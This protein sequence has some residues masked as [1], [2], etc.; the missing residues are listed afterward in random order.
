M[1]AS[2]SNFPVSRQDTIGKLSDDVLLNIFRYY[3]DA[4]PRSWPRLTRICRK[5]RHI[6]FASQRAL[7]VRLLCTHGTPVP[8]TLVC[9]PTLPVVVQYGAPPVPGLPVTEDEDNLNIIAALKQVDRVSSISLIVTNSLLKKLSAIER[10]FSELEDLVLLSQDSVSLMPSAFRWG[11][12]LHTLH[13]TRT[14]IPA[15]LELLL[16]STGLVDLKLHK[17]PNLECLPPDALSR[18]P[19][20][21]SLS[22][23]L[24]SFPLPRNDVGLPT[25][26]GERV[27]LPALTCFKYRGT[28]KYLDSFVARIDAPHLGEID[29]TFFCQPT[30]DAFQLR[31]F[32]QRIEMQ[33]SLS[34]A[35]VETSTHAISISFT[36][37]GASTPLRLQISCK[38]LDWQLSCMTQICDRIS[39]ILFHVGDLG[40]NITQLSDGQDNPGV[41]PWLDLFRSFKFGSAKRFWVAGELMTDILCVLGPASEGNTHM[42]PSLCQIRVQKPMMMDGPSWDSVQSFITKRSTP[43][44]PVEVNAPSY[45]CH[46]CH[47]S[48][49][50]QQE[51]KRHLR[52]KYGYQILCFYCGE[53]ECRPGRN[54]LFREH[55]ESKHA[56]VTRNDELIS[57]ASLTPSQ[58]VGLFNRH[59]TLR[60]PDIIKPSTTPT[61]T[62]HRPRHSPHYAPHFPDPDT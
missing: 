46:I 30:M 4:S 23:D 49:K 48:F 10:P 26:P 50:E 40:I 14:A 28:S 3:L 21:R 59:S 31:R 8:K 43:G 58:L 51:L 15:L 22:L 62:P 11:L 44:R 32:I 27:V 2:L 34:R 38:Q 17:I 20:L 60:T 57:K 39:P 6:V 24:L 33:T 42:L 52:D 45:Q 18:M 19:H 12:R 41:E 54:D 61:P 29:I 7:R 35:K 9:W 55:L 36:D 13:L 47:R 25:Q 53:F 56:E 16:H 37:S 5:W 1:P